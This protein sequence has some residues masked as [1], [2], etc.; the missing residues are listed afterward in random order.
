ML[1]YGPRAFWYTIF[2]YHEVRAVKIYRACAVSMHC[3][4][5]EQLFTSFKNMAEERSLREVNLIL[6]SRLQVT[7]KAIWKDVNSIKTNRKHCEVDEPLENSIFEGFGP[8]RTPITLRSRRKALSKLSTKITPRK[9]SEKGS[10]RFGTP[11]RSGQKENRTLA[12]STKGLN[13]ILRT[14]QSR[15]KHQIQV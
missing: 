11:R 8:D 7:Q 12:D 14:P 6:L 1:K 9:Q 4:S 10:V 15:S 13:S 3:M 5:R 2:I